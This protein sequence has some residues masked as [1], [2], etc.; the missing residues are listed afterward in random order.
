VSAALRVIPIENGQ[1]L[2]NC[3]LL[4]EAGSTEAVIV[5]PGEEPDRFLEV[6]HREGLAIREIWLTHAHLDHI[7]GVATVKAATGAP[8]L[9]HRAD[10]PLYQNL[11]QQGL[12]FG[13]RL[14]PPPPVDRY[15]EPGEL[16]A[17]GS[18]V[19]RV[20]PTPGH[21]AG[22]VCFVAPGLV[23]GGDVLFQGSIG[24]TDLPGGSHSRLL[25]SIREELLT[26]EDE[27]VV[28]PGHGPPTTVGAERRS[29]PF[30]VEA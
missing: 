1:F 7:V 17:I 19:F 21:S 2:E 20:R 27:T 11:P 12:W 18:T 22:S 13:L 15:L 28:H 25:R 5:D 30:L 3:Y 9:L 6:A 10:E 26:L 24:R 4:A 8:I 16:L 14:A 23:I 29:N